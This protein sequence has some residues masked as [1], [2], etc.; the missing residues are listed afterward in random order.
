VGGG[1]KASNE[2]NRADECKI[3]RVE[4]QNNPLALEIIQVK[5]GNLSINDSCE[6]EFELGIIMGLRC[7]ISADIEE[8]NHWRGNGVRG[9]QLEQPH[10][11]TL[12]LR[13]R[14]YC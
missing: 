6:N 13:W 1:A 10:Q 9:G 5:G 8:T 14:T 11:R 2:T 4:E 3:E 7:P 12:S